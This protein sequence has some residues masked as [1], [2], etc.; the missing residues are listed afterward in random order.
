[1]GEPQ[2]LAPEQ[3]RILAELKPLLD[4]HRLYLAGGCAVAHHAAHR[5]SLDLDFFP[6]HPNFDLVQFRDEVVSAVDQVQTLGLTDATLRLNISGSVI[7]GV[8]Y[9][10]A[11]LEQPMAGPEGVLVAGLRDLSVMKLSAVSQRGIRRDFWDLYELLHHGVNL[12][13]ALD[14]YVLRYG[15]A[16]SDLYHVLRA[17]S[18]FDDA[19]RESVMPK[20]LTVDNWRKIRSFFEQAAPQELTLRLER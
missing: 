15:K 8:N 13:E 10:Y 11:P 6:I 9:P 12:S 1:M 3:R 17:L 19:E 5:Q 16:H 20:G 4:K 14:C 2:C 18:Y 7:D